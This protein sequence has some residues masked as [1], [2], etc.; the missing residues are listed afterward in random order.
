MPYV[1]EGRF[2]HIPPSDAREWDTSYEKPWWNDEQYIVGKLTEKKRLIKVMNMLSKTENTIYVCAEETVADIQTRYMEYNK[3]SES[4]T[5][6]ALLDGEFVLL[7][8]EKTLEENGVIDETENF[9][10]LGLDDDFYVPVLHLY[11][12]D[13]LTYA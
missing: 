7:D 1:P 5:W 13:D 4:Y 8:M 3:H 10:K 6:K 12:N 9:Y 2:I 11:F